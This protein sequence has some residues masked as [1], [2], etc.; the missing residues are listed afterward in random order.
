MV[1]TVMFVT[2]ICTYALHP[3]SIFL[4]AKQDTQNAA[5]ES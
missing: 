2:I 1:L 5:E 3:R 4:D